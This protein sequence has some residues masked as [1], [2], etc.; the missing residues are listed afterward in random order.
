MSEQTTYPYFVPCESEEHWQDLN[1][2]LT[3]WK[4]KQP[5]LI[6]HGKSASYSACL[7]DSEGT[8]WLIVQ[9]EVESQISEE[10]KAQKKLHHEI[11][12]PDPEVGA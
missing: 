10:L 12:W 7:K 2:A 8:P 9:P 1:Q 3:D 11:N 4:N 6:M 5:E